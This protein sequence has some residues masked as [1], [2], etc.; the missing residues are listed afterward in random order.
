MKNHL[1]LYLDRYAEKK[2]IRIGDYFS[3]DLKFNYCLVIPAFN[4]SNYFLNQFK[5]VNFAQETVLIIVIIN[6]PDNVIDTKANQKLWFDIKSNKEII[7]ENEETLLAKLNNTYIL[8]VDC[9]N[10]NKKIPKKNGVGLARKIGCDIAC[11]LKYKRV[12][13]SNWIH[14]SDAD[15]HLP[16][17][18][19]KQ[20]PKN[21]NFSA[22]VYPFKHKM[23]EDLNLSQK[24]GEKASV[25][26]ATLIYEK[27]LNYYVDGLNYAKSA[28]AFQ[29][30]GS[31]MVM[32]LIAYTKVRGFPKR[33]GG[34]DFYCLNKLRKLGLIYKIKG[35]PIILESRLSN[36][37]PFGTGPAVKKIVAQ[38]LNQES[39][40]YY[41]PAIFKELKI[42]LEHLSCIY[43][44]KETDE[45][46]KQWLQALPTSS[47]DA[48][49]NLGIEK[50]YEHI[51]KHCD[52][53]DQC[54][55]QTQNW[56]DAF[57]TLKFIH[58]LKD[59]HPDVPIKMGIEEL[60]KMQLVI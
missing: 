36:R 16:H 30:L 45:L 8:G 17:D 1:S 23:F 54:I 48:L 10:D 9:F 6:Q 7:F 41:N 47:Q 32:N 55:K 57:K 43:S 22:A 40:L 44:V 33:A 26:Q 14:T 19:F 42:V 12:L 2:S 13:N 4:E 58:L 5:A 53:L 51:Q 56:F 46:F 25:D 49:I 29:T 15:A 35:D 37:A 39:Y 21:S 38:E 34:E 24:N 11:K 60:K 52:D 20:T 27:A 3:S 18:Y 50:L 31:C 28:Y 59:S